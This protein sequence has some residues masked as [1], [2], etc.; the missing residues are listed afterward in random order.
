MWDPA[1]N[2]EYLNYELAFPNFLDYSWPKFFRQLCQPSTLAMPANW[3]YGFIKRTNQDSKTWSEVGSKLLG[4]FT[5]SVSSVVEV[6]VK[7]RGHQASTY[8]SKKY[9]D[10]KG[11][12]RENVNPAPAITRQW[13]IKNG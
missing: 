13:E 10:R 8:L 9:I 3:L 1:K 2:Y 7:P 5:S 12:L 6:V 4:S 11:R